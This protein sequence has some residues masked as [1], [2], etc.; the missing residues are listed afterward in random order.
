MKRWS[1]NGIQV[2][3][4]MEWPLSQVS[5][6]TQ[7]T[8][9]CTQQVRRSSRGRKELV[10]LASGQRGDNC[11]GK[12]DACGEKVI[13]GVKRDADFIYLAHWNEILEVPDQIQ[14]FWTLD[15]KKEVRMVSLLIY[16]SAEREKTLQNLAGTK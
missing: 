5:L 10:R 13:F 11:S 7:L 9:L 12:L 4:C 3:I 15:L 2:K 8:D 1:S 14:L 6:Y 16:L